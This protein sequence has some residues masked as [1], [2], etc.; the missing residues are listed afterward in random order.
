MPYV[1]VPG[2]SNSVIVNPYGSTANLAIAQQI[3]NA[4]AQAKSAGNL[5]VQDSS[6]LGTLPAGK[7]GEV[8]V[9]VASGSINV[10][11]G[12]TFT[13]IG[14][15]TAGGTSSTGPFTVGGGGS[16]FI[17][18]QPVTYYGAASSAAVL[19]AAGNGNDL[20]SLPT[21]S[22]YTVGLGNGNDTINAN[23]SG[24]VTGG[25]GNNIFFAG[26]LGTT[27]GPNQINSYGSADTIVA[28]GGSTSVST[29]G[30]NPLVFGGAGSLTYFG[31][32][33]GAPTIV[34]GTG[35]EII[36]AGSGQN[37]TFLGGATGDQ[38]AAGAGNETL[39]AGGS[40]AN[41]S[42]AI[43]SGTVDVIGS[44]GNDTFFGGSGVATI[45]SN[46]GSDLFVFGNVAGHTD[47]TLTITDFNT[48]KDSLSL[49]GVTVA[50]ETGGSSS[51]LVTLSDGTKITFLGITNPGSIVT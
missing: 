14:P 26:G 51:S 50:S 28:G 29:Y 16:L 5:F 46:G 47:G 41:I 11:T 42:M 40:S 17:G 30:S 22:T 19:I 2:A 18:D 32:A 27:G 21:G 37:L 39:N 36:F 24:T 3:A 4:L 8:A 38:L 23:G 34:G 31:D 6:S 20:I 35:S 43:G 33:P 49:S 25:T 15:S 12:Y 45:T 1:T 10:P 48:S 9:T 44:K 13:A 7:I